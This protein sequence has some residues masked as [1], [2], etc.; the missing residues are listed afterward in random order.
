[1]LIIPKKCNNIIEIITRIKVGESGILI[2][3]LLK[4]N[5][6]TG[7]KIMNNKNIKRIKIVKNYNCPIC[8]KVHDIGLY[9]RIEYYNYNNIKFNCENEFYYCENEFD[10]RDKFEEDELQFLDDELIDKVGA[11]EE[12]AREKAYYMEN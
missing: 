9:S 3:I 12:E 1:M 10:G 7:V 4:K 11:R 6:N 8:G 5:G 2:K